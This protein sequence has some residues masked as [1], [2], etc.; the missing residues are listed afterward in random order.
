MA[1]LNHNVNVWPTGR[2]GG[3]SK[4]K[5][6]RRYL[7]SNVG[8]AAGFA[9]KRPFGILAASVAVGFAAWMLIQKPRL[10]QKLVRGS[11]PLSAWIARRFIRG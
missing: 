3:E 4:S 5:R 11:V 7:E 8:A 10:T 1:S 6:L 9:A 2:P